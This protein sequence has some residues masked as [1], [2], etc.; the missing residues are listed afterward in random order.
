MVRDL[1]GTP[2]MGASVE[3]FPETAGNVTTRDFLTDTQGIFRGEK[4]IAGVVYDSSHSRR[5][6]SHLAATR[7]HQSKSDN[8]G[9]N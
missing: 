5:F 4:T 9:T 7:A 6:S 8:T 1:T 3:V 2:Q